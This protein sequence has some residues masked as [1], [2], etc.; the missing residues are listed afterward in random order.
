M[1][2]ILTGPISNIPRNIQNVAYSMGC[3]MDLQIQHSKVMW[4]VVMDP[5]VQVVQ[6]IVVCVIKQK[7]AVVFYSHCSCT[8]QLVTDPLLKHYIHF[9]TTL[10]S[11]RAKPRTLLETSRA[12]EM[13]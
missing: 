3:N 13:R 7:T 8:I 6:E 11:F 12:S 9:R 5:F 2:S 4:R 10:E 1:N